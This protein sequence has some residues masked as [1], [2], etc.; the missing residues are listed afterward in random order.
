MRP[1]TALS[2]VLDALRQEPVRAMLGV[3]RH[4]PLDYEAIKA[5]ASGGSADAALKQLTML[6]AVRRRRSNR[7]SSYEL[8][9]TGGDFRL[10]VGAA[11]DIPGGQAIFDILYRNGGVHVLVHHLGYLVHD[12]RDYPDSTRAGVTRRLR[13]AGVLNQDRPPKLVDPEGHRALLLH[14]HLLAYRVHEELAARARADARG[15]QIEPLR[16]EDTK[17]VRHMMRPTVLEEFDAYDDSHPSGDGDGW[18]R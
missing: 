6:G 3:L 13:D 18:R 2:Y 16:P 17:L 14:L 8:T 11:D 10:A 15:L 5:L 9:D 1:V 7:R 4:G 12:L